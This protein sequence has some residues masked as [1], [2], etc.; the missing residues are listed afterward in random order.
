MKYKKLKLRSTKASIKEFK[1]SILWKDI[2]R[3]LGT[4]RKMAEDEIIS[5]AEECSD[6]KD[7]THI[8]RIGGRTEA[9]DYMLEILDIF[10][11]EIDDARYNE[12]N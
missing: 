10:I 7:L 4:W 1:N 11:Q 6:I 5:L 12:T 8:A 9:I 2:K 3:E